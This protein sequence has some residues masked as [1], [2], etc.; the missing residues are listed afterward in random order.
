LTNLRANFDGQEEELKP[1]Q[2]YSSEAAQVEVTAER[3][4]ANW[5]MIRV[6]IPKR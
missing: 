6:E 4:A 3:E 5:I 1:G 2:V